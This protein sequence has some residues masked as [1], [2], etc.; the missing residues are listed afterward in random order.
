[1]IFKFVHQNVRQNICL[2]FACGCLIYYLCKRCAS[3]FFK[4]FF[5]TQ[6]KKVIYDSSGSRV[7]SCSGGGTL[8]VC[9]CWD[10]MLRGSWGLK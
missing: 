8:H 7:S 1:M 5:F 3:P 10:D 2:S 4:S 9:L 6:E